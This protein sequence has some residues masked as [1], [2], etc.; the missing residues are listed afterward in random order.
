MLSK[1]HKKLSTSH[2]KISRFRSDCLFDNVSGQ[3]ITQHEIE[4]FIPSLR[5]RLF[6]DFQGERWIY[7]YRMIFVKNCIGFVCILWRKHT[8]LQPRNQRNCRFPLCKCLGQC[9]IKIC[10]YMKFIESSRNDILEFSIK[11]LRVGDKNI[12][13][14]I[15][16]EN[17]NGHANFYFG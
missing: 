9:P 1:K 7:F 2:S 15:S 12:G 13:H 8:V 3:T 17:K 14:K 4:L 6:F 10:N 11:V 16:L 5:H